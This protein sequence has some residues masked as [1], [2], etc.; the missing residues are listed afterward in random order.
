MNVSDIISTVSAAISF[1][2]CLAAI[3]YARE[4]GK[5]SDESK[6]YE[7]RAN[8]IA[9]GQSETSVY[10]EIAQSRFL[11]DEASLDIAKLFK[12]TGSA[13]MS[14]SDKKFLEILGKRLNSRIEN[15]ANVY[16][17]AC[18]LYLGTKIDANRFELTYT[19]SI[20]SLCNESAYKRQMQPEATSKYKNIW[21]VYHK[22][23]K[24]GAAHS[25]VE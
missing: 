11:I 18:G 17:V 3:Y 4:S 10:S 6:Y 13:E 16:E 7:C 24:D 1:V 25:S 21:E 14:A 8:A 15:Y 12:E 9:M 22:L 2:S 23:V 5:S 19:D 20:K